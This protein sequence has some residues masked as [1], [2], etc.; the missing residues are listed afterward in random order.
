MEW[1]WDNHP[2]HATPNVLDMSF[3]LR[4]HDRSQFIWLLV[5][6]KDLKNVK[7]TPHMSQNRIYLWLT[8]LTTSRRKADHR[9]R[10]LEQYIYCLLYVLRSWLRKFCRVRR[11]SFPNKTFNYLFRQMCSAENVW[12]TVVECLSQL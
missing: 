9:A 2:N 11:F 6:N 3:Q 1:T 8:E 5:I 12:L 4:V 7:L 10:S